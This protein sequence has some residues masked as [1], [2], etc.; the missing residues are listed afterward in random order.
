LLLPLPHDTLTHDTDFSSSL[1]KLP[2]PGLD[3]TDHSIPFHTSTNEL[4][5]PIEV[6]SPT[7]VHEDTLKHDT[8]DN[9]LSEAPVLGLDTTDHSVPFHISINVT[10]PK[11]VLV[12]PTATHQASLTH[13]AE[14]IR[15][16]LLP[17]F[18]LGTTTALSTTAPAGVDT[19]TP[20]N[21]I[22]I[23]ANI[24]RTDLRAI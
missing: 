13:A 11:S 21:T 22:A 14:D 2:A 3:T 19:T 24:A 4:R 5:G 10:L 9:T 12:K 7:A 17:A 16:M 6:E 8:E 18:G 15:S 1:R 20:P 23:T